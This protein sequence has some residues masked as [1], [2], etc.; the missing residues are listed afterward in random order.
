[1]KLLQFCNVGNV[2]GGTGACGWTITRCFP[3]WEHGVHFRPAR[4]PTPETALA[5]EG[6]HI[7]TG[8]KTPDE[9][10]YE[11]K[12]DVIIF[13]NTPETIFPQALPSN[14]VS[15]FYQHS[16]LKEF[17]AT[18]K[19]CDVAFCVS[20]YLADVVGF[21]KRFVLYQPVPLAPYAAVIGR[22]P[23]LVGRIC[24][25]H[26][27]KWKEQDVLPVYRHLKETQPDLTYEF[28]GAPESIQGELWDLFGERVSFLRPS[29]KARERF[30]AWDMM[31]YSTSV[32]ETYG[33]TVCEAQRA[34][35]VPIVSRLGG[36]IE[37]VRHGVDGYLCD[38][39]SDFSRAVISV[40]SGRIDR[41]RM[42]ERGDAR[43]SMRVF[44]DKILA[45]LEVFARG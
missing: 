18:S 13:H 38:N 20:E 2:V 21:D 31:I 37:Q 14:A 23:G 22:H 10:I 16:A 28:V 19:R 32:T 30:N 35:C 44:R 41:G 12:P 26:A 17:A 25:P 24:T 7:F 8:H 43:G 39:V 1:M 34:G 4:S 11:F 29:W 36:F 5:F 15:I 6:C 45:T 42:I 40:L 9:A 3:D 27:G 33:R